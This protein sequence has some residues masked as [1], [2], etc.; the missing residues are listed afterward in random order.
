MTILTTFDREYEF[1]TKYLELLDKFKKFNPASLFATKKKFSKL[2]LELN[3]LER[4]A[5][6]FYKRMEKV[7]LENEAESIGQE[8]KLPDKYWEDSTNIDFLVGRFYNVQPFNFREPPYQ[9]ARKKVLRIAK[10]KK[11]KLLNPFIA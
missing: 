5:N 8:V 9:K 4:E 10:D 11:I 1:I 2:E 3:K 7:R 6:N